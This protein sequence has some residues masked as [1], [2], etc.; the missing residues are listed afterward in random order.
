MLTGSSLPVLAAGSSQPVA[1]RAVQKATRL[2]ALALGQSLRGFRESTDPL[3]QAHAFAREQSVLAALFAEIAELLGGRLDKLPERRRPHYTP[4][5]R[6]RILEIKRLLALS[7][8]ETARLFRVSI[9]TVL[10]WEAEAG[11]EPEKTTIGSLLKP[12]PPLRR[13]ADVV[14]HLVQRMD[15]LGF[16]SAEKIAATLARAGWRLARE[17]V[18]RYRHE[19][20]VKPHPGRARTDRATPPLRAR[21]PNDLWFLDITRVKGLFGLLSFRVASVFD[22]FSRMPV[23]LRVFPAEPRAEDMARLVAVARRRHGAPRHVVSDCGGQFEADAF[24]RAL[25]AFG[26]P[27]RFGAVGAKGSIALIERFW[28]TLKQPLRLPLF[29]PLCQVDLEERLAYAVLHYSFYRPH[30]ALQGMTPAEVFF[31]WPAAHHKATFPPRGHRGEPGRP[32][33]FQIAFLDPHHRHPILIK[34]A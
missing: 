33:P 2:L 11:R 17:T 31:G 24:E 27:H 10:R 22:G 6:W 28:R 21:H 19:P 25:E 5:Q 26:I 15:R 23:A 9:G 13:F 32:P 18:R 20:P 14:R 34:A 3:L 12:T 7:A 4:A 29:R 8:E 16:G 1:Q 30:E